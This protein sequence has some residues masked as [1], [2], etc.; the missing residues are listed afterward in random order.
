MGK[1]GKV[2]PTKDEKSKDNQ[3]ERKQEN[4]SSKSAS[5]DAIAGTGSDIKL[6]SLKVVVV[7]D[8]VSR[9]LAE[10]ALSKVAG[11]EVAQEKKVSVP[12]KSTS[13][14]KKEAVQ[15]SHKRYAHLL[16]YYLYLV[17]LLDTTLCCLN[18]FSG[19]PPQEG[20]F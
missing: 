3:K 5:P 14:S 1:R 16:E 13:T 19:I 17:L 7:I 9:L 10:Q 2:S 4:S 11:G 12:P 15:S 20:N 18:I 8:S 6:E